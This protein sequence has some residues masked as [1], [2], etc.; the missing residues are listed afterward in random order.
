MWT[1]TNDF[2]EKPGALGTS[3]ADFQGSKVSLL[4]HRFLLLDGDGEVYYEGLSDD[5]GS[6]RGFA[7]LD[8]FGRS[9]AGC[10]EIRYLANGSW[11]AL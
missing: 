3:S 4:K 5:C 8:D 9:F 10:T 7:P 6:Q 2:L 11:Q 1:I